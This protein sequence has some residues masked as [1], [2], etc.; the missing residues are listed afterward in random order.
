[1]ATG[2][3]EFKYGFKYVC[4][5]YSFNILNFRMIKLNNSNQ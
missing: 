4:F 1:M 5:F 3:F 2:N